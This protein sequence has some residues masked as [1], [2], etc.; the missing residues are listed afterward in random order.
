[1]LSR[2]NNYKDFVIPVL[3]GKVADSFKNISYLEGAEGGKDAQG[4]VWLAYSTADGVPAIAAVAP[5]SMSQPSA[6]LRDGSPA[7][8]AADLRQDGGGHREVE[9]SPLRDPMSPLTRAMVSD[10]AK[11]LYMAG[12]DAWLICSAFISKTYFD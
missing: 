7:R 12:C 5:G 4:V 11:C 1:M 3:N 2:W 9:D 8:S 6:P 10:Q